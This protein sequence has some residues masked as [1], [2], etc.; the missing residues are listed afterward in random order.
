MR[1]KPLGAGSTALTNATMTMGGERFSLSSPLLRAA[2]EMQ[3]KHDT[4]RNEHGVYHARADRWNL[5]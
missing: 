4:K 5:A 2:T 3:R 1:I